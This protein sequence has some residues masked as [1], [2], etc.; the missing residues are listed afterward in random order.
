VVALLVPTLWLV[1]AIFV[2][3]EGNF[4]NP[5][6]DG[7]GVTVAF[8]GIPATIW[9]LARIIWPEFG[10]DLSLSRRA[11]VMASVVLIA[12]CF[13]FTRRESSRLFDV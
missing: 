1:L 3:A 5:L 12:R 7:L 6:I 9:V 13:L 8:L 4:L 10:E 11:G 2:R